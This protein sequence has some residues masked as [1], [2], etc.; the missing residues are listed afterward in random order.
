MYVNA[1]HCRLQRIHFVCFRILHNDANVVPRGILLFLT[2]L[3]IIYLRAIT[4]HCSKE[5]HICTS[6]REENDVS[7]VQI[8]RDQRLPVENMEVITLKE[9]E[10]VRIDLS[11]HDK[12]SEQTDNRI[13]YFLSRS[14]LRILILVVEALETNDSVEHEVTEQQDAETN[15]L[16]QRS[17]LNL[18]SVALIEAVV[19]DDVDNPNTH[20]TD[21]LQNGSV[22]GR[23]G[24]GDHH[25]E[26]VVEQNSQNVEDDQNHQRLAV[27]EHVQSINGV[28]V[29][30]LLDQLDLGV[31]SAL[32][33]HQAD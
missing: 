12:N 16:N 20:G 27:L 21:S 6:P 23:E 31:S 15:Q 3:P 29:E 18:L 19:D 24:L 25:S 2:I 28:L 30:H 33:N 14:R 4:K 13:I 9:V 32:D 10:L 1:I 26:Q 7:S 22:D 5:T 8:I 11:L 17:K